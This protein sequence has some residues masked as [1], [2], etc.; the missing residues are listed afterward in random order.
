MSERPS[1]LAQL[2]VRENQTFL[3]ATVVIGVLAG[4]SAVLFSLSIDIATRS[5]FGFSPSAVRLFLVPTGLS[6]VAG[7]LLA[8]VFPEVRGSGVPQTKT[9]YHLAGGVLPLRVAIGKFLTGVLCI[10]AGHSLG[11]EGPSVQIGAALASAAGGWLRLPAHRI[12][13]LVPVGAAGA[14]AAA[15]NTPVAAV[16]FTLE[17][18]IG[19]TN[20]PLIGSTVIASVASVI[21]ARSLLGDAPLFHVPV[22]ELVHPA[23]LAAYACLGLVGGVLSVL[24][25]KGLLRARMA[26]RRLPERSRW[27]H[28][29][30][31]GVIIGGMLIVT[32]GVLGVGYEYVDQAL[33]SGLLLQTLL[34]LCGMKLVATI[35]SY[36]S[37]NAGGV[38]APSLFIG[39]M[40]G[41]AV[42]VVVNGLAPFPTADPGAYALVGMGTLFAGIIRAPMT[43]VVMIFEITQDYQIIVPLMVANMLSFVISR[44]YQPEPLYH[45]LLLQDGV[46]LPTADRLTGDGHLPGKR[47]RDVMVPAGDELLTAPGDGAHVHPDHTLDVVLERLARTDGSLPVLDRRDTRQ[48]LG[49]ITRDSL[50]GRRPG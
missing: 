14:L 24:F 23:E 45:A 35:V 34:V 8:Y 18:I 12:R 15:F 29:A 19:D 40:A 2:R 36:A 27:A 42:G 3:A 22:Y 7:L 43:S 41:G 20:A 25:A 31:G 39:A 30:L 33:N 26:L 4:L 17:E 28:P 37:G 38:F 46:H 50:L 21:V 11:R 47:A 32:P 48:V 1:A 9:A 44:H 13:E 49:V 10:G 16:L 6:L 5:F